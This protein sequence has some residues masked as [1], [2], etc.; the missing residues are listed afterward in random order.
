MIEVRTVLEDLA[1]RYAVRNITDT[2]IAELRAIIGEMEAYLAKGDL[3]GISAGNTRLH[4]R[5]LQI[6]DT[7]PWR[8]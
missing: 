7:K 8:A 2:E 6:A 5:L 3:L 1:V 4:N